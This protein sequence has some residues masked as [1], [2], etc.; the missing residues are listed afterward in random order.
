M[1]GRDTRLTRLPTRSGVLLHNGLCPDEPP[2][3]QDHLLTVVE[4]GSKVAGLLIMPAAWVPPFAALPAWISEEWQTNP[5]DWTEVAKV[6]SVDIPQVFRLVSGGGQCDVILRSSAVGEGLEDRG[7]YRSIV[8]RKGQSVDS[9]IPALKE[10]YADL[11]MRQRHSRMGICVQRYF[12][13]DIAGHVSNEVHLS[14]TR[15]QWKYEIELPS[16]APDKGLNSK[17]AT[18]PTET[19][20]L[21]VNRQKDLPQALRRACHWIN[22]RIAG[23]S[24]VE[25]CVSSDHL[26]IVQVDQ[27]SPTS[28][29]EDPHRMPPTHFGEPVEAPVG[30]SCFRRYRIQEDTPWKKLNNLR[31]FWIGKEPPKHRLYYAAADEVEKLL[32]DRANRKKL[33]TEINHL[34]SSRAV[35][36]TDCRDKNIRAFNLPRTHTVNGEEAVLWL[37]ETIAEMKSRGASTRDVAFVLHQYIPARAAAWSYFSPGDALVRVDCLW[38]LPDGL[39][40]LSHD[41]FELEAR[42]GEEV[43][44][45][46]RFKRDFLQEQ[47]D[48]SWEYVPVARQFGRDRVLSKD[49]LRSIALQTVAVAD[50]LGERAQ[51]MWFCDL[52]PELELGVH[53]PWYRSRDYL[54]HNQV[55]RPPYRARHVRT[56][57][58][59]DALESEQGRFILVVQPTAE[60]V[61]ADDKFL[62]RVIALALNK[63]APVELAGSVLGHAYYRLR[64]EG[65]LVLTSQPRYPRSR[66][67]TSH[68]KLVRDAIPAN[69]AAKG[70]RVSFGRLAQEEAITALVG[71]L[72]EEG[73]EVSAASS[74]ELRVEE[75]ADVLEVLRGLAAVEKVDWNDLVTVANHK[76]EKRGGFENQTVL[77]ETAKPKRTRDG[78]LEVSPGDEPL[79]SLHKIGI[80]S[81]SE[82]KVMVPFTRLVGS[83]GVEAEVPFQGGHLLASVEVSSGGVIV[84]LRAKPSIEA[85][86]HNQPIL[87]DRE[88]NG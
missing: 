39:Q 17:F 64:D 15:N 52:P 16:Y 87:F 53:L 86:H 36:R 77:L 54:L 21:R 12:S 4:Y 59:L 84:S 81:V 3:H 75:L 74:S 29:G 46:V 65:V 14:A 8:I 13:P 76:R 85:E 18:L 38:G 41:S 79:V 26:W 34:T 58:D 63:N 66:G 25:W 27:E 82:G 80:V 19:V 56:L 33:I 51:I 22:L 11:V 48:G 37:D 28:A 50:R 10:I 6:H 47:A 45:A 60:L 31:D 71:K 30:F 57:A 78:S 70:E 49:A 9:V 32:F 7:Q 1:S 69:I 61:R 73:L 44:A 24:H 40:F 42:T 35:L 20:A 83:A 23:R 5:D 62:D 88:E 72:F 2:K 43:A 68:Q 67:K 55:E